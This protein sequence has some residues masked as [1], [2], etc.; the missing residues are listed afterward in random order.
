M[1]KFAIR[2]RH[3]LRFIV[4]IRL[5]W[6]LETVGDRFQL[7]KLRFEIDILSGCLCIWMEQCFKNFVTSH[8]RTSVYYVNLNMTVKRTLSRLRRCW[9]VVTVLIVCDLEGHFHM[10]TGAMTSGP[11]VQ[12]S[13][14]RCGNKVI[15]LPWL[16]FHATWGWSKRSGKIQTV[17]IYDVSNFIVTITKTVDFQLK[18]LR[19]NHS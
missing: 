3:N 16:E 15:I 4:I 11:P 1:I 7:P 12:V 17:F 18:S 10:V 2:E 13:F 5:L 9:Q 14:G 19:L 8:K 6:S